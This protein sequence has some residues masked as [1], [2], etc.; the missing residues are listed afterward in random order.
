MAATFKEVRD[1]CKNLKWR[2][3]AIDAYEHDNLETEEIKRI[4]NKLEEEKEAGN[5]P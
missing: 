3:D 4:R 5:S 2:D 1:V